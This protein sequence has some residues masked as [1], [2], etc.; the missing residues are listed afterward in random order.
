MDI[1][2]SFMEITT[3]VEAIRYT[4]TPMRRERD[5]PFK[6]SALQPACATRARLPLLSRS[7]SC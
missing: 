4:A 6:I 3:R 5:T 1:L 7:I 2:S